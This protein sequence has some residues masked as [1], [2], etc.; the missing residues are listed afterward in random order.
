VVPAL[1]DVQVHPLRAALA[2]PPGCAAQ[3]LT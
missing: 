1:G 2:G 3:L